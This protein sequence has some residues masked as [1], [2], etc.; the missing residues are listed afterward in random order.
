M[1][2]ADWSIHSDK[3]QFA[4][5]CVCVGTIQTYK[6]DLGLTAQYFGSF[7]KEQPC[8]RAVR[9]CS[10][11]LGCM[12]ACLTHAAHYQSCTEGSGQGCSARKY[13]WGLDLFFLFCFVFVFVFLRG[14]GLLSWVLFLWWHC[15]HNSI[16][17][18]NINVFFLVSPNHFLFPIRVKTFWPRRSQ[19]GNRPAQIQTSCRRGP[20]SW[21]SRWALLPLGVQVLCIPPN[22]IWSFQTPFLGHSHFLCP[23]SWLSLWVVALDTQR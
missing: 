5:T 16:S 15:S 12:L 8:P 22:P 1:W 14:G 2:A 17:A 13:L 7:K 20:C 9:C 4:H 11:Q 21:P 3:I 23:Q 19:C 18:F 6:R 10:G